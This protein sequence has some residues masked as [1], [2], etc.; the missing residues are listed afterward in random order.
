MGQT[1]ITIPEIIEEED[2]FSVKG[3][4]YVL[5][6]YDKDINSLKVRAFQCEARQLVSKYREE[7]TEQLYKYCEEHGGHNWSDWGEKT[8]KMVFGYKTYIERLCWNCNKSEIK[9]SKF[10]NYK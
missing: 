5:R 1:K 10:E 3:E 9:D 8:K 2:G 6:S 7:L 4:T